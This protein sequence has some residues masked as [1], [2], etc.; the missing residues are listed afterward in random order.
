LIGSWQDRL[1]LLPVR[2]EV[3]AAGTRS[4]PHPT[5]ATLDAEVC[6][7]RAVFY[8]LQMSPFKLSGSVSLISLHPS[9]NLQNPNAQRKKVRNDERCW[10]V[11]LP[12]SNH[13]CSLRGFSCRASG[14]VPV[15]TAF[16]KRVHHPILASGSR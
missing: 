4:L 5:F 2:P 13:R 3:A 11:V 10:C 12:T 16:R 15:I 6:Q 9:K 14:L 1:I 7:T 8:P